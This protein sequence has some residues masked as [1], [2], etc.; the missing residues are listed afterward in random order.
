MNAN[1]RRKDRNHFRQ[2]PKYMMFNTFPFN[3]G[4]PLFTVMAPYGGLEWAVGRAIP[5][6]S[7][8]SLTCSPLGCLV[9]PI[10]H[11]DGLLL[12]GSRHCRVALPFRLMESSYVSSIEHQ[13]TFDTLAHPS[14]NKHKWRFTTR[15]IWLFDTRSICLFFCGCVDKEKVGWIRVISTAHS[16]VVVQVVCSICPKTLMKLVVYPQTR[17]FRSLFR[18]LKFDF[19]EQFPASSKALTIK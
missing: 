10:K 19:V 8:S 1:C 12:N 2:H 13:Y 9:W 16:K 18:S 17:L 7:C 6:S 3:S 11:C 14:L 5:V 4:H 15:H